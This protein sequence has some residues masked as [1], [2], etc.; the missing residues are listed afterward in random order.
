MPMCTH[1]ANI[2]CNGDTTAPLRLTSMLTNFGEMPISDINSTIV[3]VLGMPIG[4]R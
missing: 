1:I 3:C 2:M 4:Y